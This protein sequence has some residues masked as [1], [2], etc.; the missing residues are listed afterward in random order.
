MK[1]CYR[2]VSYDYNPLQVKVAEGPVVGKYRGANWHSTIL[3][4]N[5]V[6]QIAATLTYR[7]VTYHTNGQEQ[8][9][10]AVPQA[11]PVPAKFAPWR[12]KAASEVAQ[13]HRTSVL[14]TL[15][16]RLQVAHNKGDTNLIHILE[17]E[18]KQLA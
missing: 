15:E 4:D 18:W 6:P 2:G 17:A 3:I 1:L 9:A 7:G 11:T 13:A 16:H 12:R 10:Q 8:V 5:P 14:K